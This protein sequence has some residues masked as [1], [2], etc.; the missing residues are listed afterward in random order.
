[1]R[2]ESGERT[3]VGVNDFVDDD[4]SVGGIELFKPDPGVLD[5]QLKR[6]ADVKRERHD[7]AVSD[8]LMAIELAAPNL[9][10]TLMPLIETAVRAR[11]TGGEICDVLRGQWGEHSPSTVF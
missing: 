6:L 8:A 3:I 1:M 10:T 11:A 4:Y 2:I 5:R 7:K 9:K